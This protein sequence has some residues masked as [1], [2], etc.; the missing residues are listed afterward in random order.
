MHEVVWK[1][2]YH[3]EIFIEFCTFHFNCVDCGDTASEMWVGG[4][5]VKYVIVKKT[6]S[7]FV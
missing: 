7:F 5:K 1:K 6:F 4:P 2:D 3:R